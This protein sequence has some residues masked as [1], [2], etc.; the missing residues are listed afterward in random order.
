MSNIFQEQKE[1]Y[2]HIIAKPYGSYRQVVA[3]WL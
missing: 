2:D 3:I 1:I